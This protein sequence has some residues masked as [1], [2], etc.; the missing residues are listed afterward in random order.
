MK[1]KSNKVKKRSKRE[2]GIRKS[3]KIHRRKKRTK[4]K[5]YC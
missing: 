1:K 3:K 5:G 4:L 2:N